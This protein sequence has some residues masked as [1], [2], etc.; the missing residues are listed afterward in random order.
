M[1]ASKIEKRSWGIDGQQDRSRKKQE[2][3]LSAT[4]KLLAK[5]SFR[6][7]TVSDIVRKANASTSSF[8]QRFG[9]KTGLLG[10]LFEV[11]SEA[12]KKI[13][14]ELLDVERWK[15]IP[16]A[17]ALRAAFPIILNG[18]RENQDLIRAFIEQ[19]STDERFHQTWNTLGAYTAEKIKAIVQARIHEVGHP[20]PLVGVDDALDLAYG[21]IVYELQMRRIDGS[22]IAAKSEQIIRMILA[23]MDIED[24]PS[25][26]TARKSRGVKRIK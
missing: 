21:N 7:I 9:D 12:Q 25:N 17:Q 2:A 16:L 24:V 1:A 13:I 10:C 23:Y 22:K 5:R 8:Y 4:Q 14:D 6:E 15:D 18:Y 26:S 19:A 3:I 20:D 11:H